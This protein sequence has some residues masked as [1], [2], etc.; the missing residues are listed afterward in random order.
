MTSHDR[1]PVI[2]TGAGSGIGR[3]TAIRLSSLGHPIALVDRAP[4]GLDETSTSLH[5]ESVAIVG[6]LSELDVAERIVEDATAGLEAP[7]VLVNAAGILIRRRFLEYDAAAWDSTLRVN[8]DAPFWLST[9]FV[10]GLIAT[11]LPGSIV[12]VASIEALYPLTG[13]VAYS[14]SKGAVL[15]L[16]KAMA[17]DLAPMNIR[18]NAVCPGVIATPMNEDLRADPE[19]SAQL[20]RQV[21]MSRFGEPDEVAKAVAFLVSDE[22]SY[23]TGT[24][25][26]VDGGWAA[27]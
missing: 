19:R 4:E 7:S 1:P 2:V 26:L 11:G 16:T 12:N 22:A 5:S 6:D 9:H 13:H 10:K 24:Y 27:H 23:V 25:L 21:P 8:L 14:A 15:M 3:A 20:L 17:I 18:V